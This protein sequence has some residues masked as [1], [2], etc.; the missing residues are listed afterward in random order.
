MQQQLRTVLFLSTSYSLPTQV[1]SLKHIYRIILQDS[2]IE[3]DKAGMKSPF[4]TGDLQDYGKFSTLFEREHRLGEGGD[5]IVWA[6][7]HISSKTLVAVKTPLDHK[8][9]TVERLE[10]EIANLQI[11]RQHDHIAGMLAFSKYHLP[12]GPAIFL[13]LCELGDLLSYMDDW[14]DQ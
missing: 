4:E 10:N 6:Y 2:S 5:G 7:E 11:L 8:S 12:I 14:R 13:S 3:L 1:D 9:K